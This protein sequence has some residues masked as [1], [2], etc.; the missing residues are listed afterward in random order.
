MTKL[1]VALKVKDKTG[2]T[3]RRSIEAVDFF[4]DTIKEA[5]KQ[6]QAVRIMKL[7]SF[8]IKS[9]QPRKSRNPR[10]GERVFVPAK[11]VTSFRPGKALLD[12]VNGR[13][14]SPDAT[15]NE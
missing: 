8:Y 9:K 5:V 13:K 10:T 12:L 15:S 1:K 3:R 2:F 4:L 11:N 6:G 14:S 7:G